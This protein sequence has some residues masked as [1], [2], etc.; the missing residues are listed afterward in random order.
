MSENL[1]IVESPAKAKTIEKFLG[2]KFKVVSSYGHISDLP[3]KELGVDVTGDFSPNYI[4]NDDKKKVVR[5][6]RTL[7]KKAEIIWLASDE[8]REGEAIAWHLAQ[9]L[10]LNQQRTKRIVF[11]EITKDAIQHAIQHPRPIN[12]HLVDAQQARRV[13]DRLVG[14]ELSPI[15]WRKV[16]GGLSAGRVQSVSVRIIVERE[17]EIEA[18][19]PKASF[20]IQAVFLTNSGKAIK[21]SSAATYETAEEANAF[22]SQNIGAAFAVSNLEKKPASKSPTAPF[23]TSTLQQEASRKL[24]FSVSRTMS[25]AQRLYEAGHITYMRTDSVNLSKQALNEAREVIT[26]AYGPEY[27]QTRVFKTKNKGAQEA[28]EAIRPTKLASMRV[29]AAPDE[30]RLYELIWK[31]TVASQMSDAKLERSV[32]Q[33]SADKHDKKFTARGEVVTFEG[34][35]K[36]YFEGKDEEEDAQEG[37]LPKVTQ[38]EQLGAKTITATERF[39]RPPA[40]Y[41]EASLVKRLEELGIGRPSTYAPTITTIINRKYIEKGTVEGDERNYTQLVLTQNEIKKEI[42]SERVGSEK[43]KLVPTDVGMLVNDFLVKNFP[44][45]ID[46]N[47]TAEVE[48]GFDSIALGNEDW[49]SMMKSFYEDFHPVVEDVKENAQ[50]EIGERILGVDPKTGRQLS[51]RLGKFGAM[52]QIGTAEEEEKPLFA[53]LH[54]DQQLIKITFEQA[55]DLFKLPLHLGEFDA[56][57]VEVNNGRYGPYVR[58]GKTFI[59]LPKGKNPLTTTLDEA[60]EYIEEKRIADAPI[61]TYE[62]LPVTKGVGRFGPFIKWNGWFVN[63]SKKYDYDNLTAADIAQLIEDKKKKEAERIVHNW[64]DEGVRVE[65]ARWGRHNIIKGKQKV[66][67]Q[68]TIDV[69]EMTLTQAMSYLEKQKPK[70]KKRTKKK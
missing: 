44:R 33:I 60:I 14:Y 43:G 18:F 48:Q 34:F 24:G 9:Q 55:L 37:L 28:H 23:T 12:Q 29:D 3:A 25:N 67:L 49:K 35:L 42:H 65:K 22:L 20:K 68:K 38:G 13:L 70:K 27:A 45:V 7:A 54:P 59:S 15:L 51:V 6:L 2:D 39:T 17:R 40:R 19:T 66:E 32:I 16:K 5:E 46:Y 4:V 26:N 1:V 52:A 61:A 58:H 53:S 31:R 47:F 30:Q 50:R 56:E 64:E 62:E 69:S 41:T 36:V 8:D 21:A 57:A 11:H 63:V 10:D